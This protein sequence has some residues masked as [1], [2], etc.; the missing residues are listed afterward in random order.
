M[1]IKI[2]IPQS[3][4]ILTKGEYGFQEVLDD[5]NNTNE[6]I[7]FTFNISQKN[8][9]LFN[10]IRNLNSNVKV[11]IVSNIPKRYDKY[12]Y[13]PKNGFDA[14]KMAKKNIN[15]YF[16]RMDKINFN[17][18]FL[19][20]FNFK[21]HIKI[22]LTNNIAYI[23]SQNYSEESQ[24][25]FEIGFLINDKNAIKEIKDKICNCIIGNSIAYG[26][27]ELD[28]YICRIY[29]LLD[30]LWD[31]R[32]IIDQI[33]SN[34]NEFEEKDNN[35]DEESTCGDVFQND[36][37]NIECIL[38][39]LKLIQQELKG[40][41]FYKTI[42]L[43][44]TE[45]ENIL[46]IINSCFLKDYINFDEVTE[47]SEIYNRFFKSNKTH[48]L[49]KYLNNLSS[50]DYSLLSYEDKKTL[51]SIYKMVLD[52]K[53]RLYRLCF[54]DFK[55]LNSKLEILYL[56]LETISDILKTVKSKQDCIDNTDN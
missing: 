31:S 56:E 39:E 40:K 22:V 34:M 51:N 13:N 19:P 21:N 9:N 11:T 4:L 20:Y 52:E 42:D 32:T 15:V 27:T 46:P 12:V 30:D 26:G 48:M 38:N 16:S 29:R 45:L 24:D 8:S 14:S 23:G 49:E 33:I 7:I 44:F 10:L 28:N 18:D 37:D 36:L 6:I 25:N 17:S 53:V 5:F 50:A 1:Q 54:E 3:Q 55:D 35:S 43:E 47:T 41:Q 2:P